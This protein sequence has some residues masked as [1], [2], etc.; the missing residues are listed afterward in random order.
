MKRFLQTKCQ[1]LRK[2]WD[3]HCKTSCFGFMRHAEKSQKQ[4]APNSEPAL[5][6]GQAHRFH[7]PAGWRMWLFLG[8]N[9][10]RGC[11]WGAAAGCFRDRWPFIWFYVSTSGPC[12]DDYPFCL[13][14]PWLESPSIRWPHMAPLV[15]KVISCYFTILWHLA[16]RDCIPRCYDTLNQLHVAK[17]IMF[18]AASSP[19][20]NA[21]LL[22][23]HMFEIC[24]KLLCHSDLI[25]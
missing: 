23:F 2:C 8:S 1:L 3:R 25:A 11:P 4:I 20:G 5:L 9:W 12:F 22:A 7:G 10:A 16:F 18:Q 13:E 21:M 17:M 15:S 6:T 19:T 24:L 14:E